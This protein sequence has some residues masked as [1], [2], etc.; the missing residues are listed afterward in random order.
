MG[1]EY[2][3]DSALDVTEEEY[4]VMIAISHYWQSKMECG[5]S[6]D[7]IE[8]RLIELIHISTGGR[9]EFSR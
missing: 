8:T 6:K 5:F 4:N 1:N 3:F 2:K 9:T 7:D